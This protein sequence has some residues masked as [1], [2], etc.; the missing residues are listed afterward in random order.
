L[1][2]KETTRSESTNTDAGSSNPN[3]HRALKG[4]FLSPNLDEWV[5]SIRRGNSFQNIHLLEYVTY[6]TLYLHSNKTLLFLWINFQQNCA[7]SLTSQ[8]MGKI[9]WILWDF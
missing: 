6:K 8:L 3:G 2:S 9:N 4:E 5:S 7:L 1:R